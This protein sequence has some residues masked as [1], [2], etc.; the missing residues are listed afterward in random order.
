MTWVAE[1]YDFFLANT[2]WLVALIP[3]AIVA[4]FVKISR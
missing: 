1:A 3:V 2:W 4:F